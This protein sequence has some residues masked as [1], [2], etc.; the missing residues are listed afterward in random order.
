MK[1]LLFILSA[2][3]VLACNDIENCEADENLD[4]MIVRFY[5]KGTK[6]AKK[7]GFTITADNSPYSFP[8]FTD[9]TGIALPLNPDAGQATF[10]FDSVGTDVSYDLVMSY[11]TELKIFDPKCNPSFYYSNLDTISYTFDSLSIPGTVTN[12]QISANVEIFF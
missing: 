6:A 2:F 9:S 1:K 7:V 5:N 10:H 12:I 4:V 8:P 11:D 3:G